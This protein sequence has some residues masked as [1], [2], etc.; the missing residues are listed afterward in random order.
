MTDEFGGIA[1]DGLWGQQTT[2]EAQ[3][4]WGVPVTGRIL[5]QLRANRQPGTTSGW[6]FDDDPDGEGDVL[7]KAFQAHYGL[8]ASGHLDEALI[9]AFQT[10]MGTTVDGVLSRP[11]DA[12]KEFQ[13]RLNTGDAAG[14]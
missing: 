1:E 14:T 7:I 11:S 12:V 4:T 9:R 2:R 6:E 13:R 5:N 8:D 10:R 3:L